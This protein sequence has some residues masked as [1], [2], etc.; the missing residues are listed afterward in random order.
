MAWN[1]MSFLYSKVPANAGVQEV[2]SRGDQDAL[3]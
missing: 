1:G 2:F 3:G